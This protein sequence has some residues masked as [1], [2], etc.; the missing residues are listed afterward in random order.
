[1]VEYD[2]ICIGSG[3]GAGGFGKRAKRLG[4]TVCM[5]ENSRI[6]GACVNIGCIPKKLMF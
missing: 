1:M 4:Q 5:V 6:G 2:V 3:S